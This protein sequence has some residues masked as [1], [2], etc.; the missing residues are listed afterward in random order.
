MA[1]TMLQHQDER[2]VAARLSRFDVVERVIHWTTAVL[3]LTLVGTGL[4]LYIGSLS[5]LVG[6]RELIRT[7]HVWSGLAL[8]IPLLLGVIGPWRRRL[9]DDFRRLGRWLP[10]DRQWL[11]HM[12]DPDSSIRLGKFN[13]GQKLFAALVCGA[14]P[15]MLMSGSIMRWFEPFPTTWRTGATFVHDWIALLLFVAIPIHVLKAL[16]DPILL[17]GM[18]RGWVPSRWA[19]AERPR[20]FE[21]Q[22]G[23]AE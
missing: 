21:E 12:R 13:A 20:W 3:F 16:G 14:I 11:R 19:R 5:A 23:E 1:G 17:R 4:I 2:A 6:R 9:V 18:V 8:P 22:T 15:V 10:D 7:I